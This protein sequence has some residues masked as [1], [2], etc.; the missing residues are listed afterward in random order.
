MNSVGKSSIILLLLVVCLPG[1]GQQKQLNQDTTVYGRTFLYGEINREGLTTGNN[2][3][4]FESYYNRYQLDEKTIANLDK[5]VLEGLSV[6][7]LMGTWCPDSKRNVPVFFKMMDELGFDEEKLEMHAL[8][9]RKK[10]P[11][12]VQKTY[13]VT[14][15]PT[16]I[17]YKNDQEIGRFVERPSGGKKMESMIAE[18]LKK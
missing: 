2:K 15:V 7:L 3:G 12:N 6:R 16:I 9:L 4:W 8:D 5:E 18:I 14:R 11:D 1:I 13:N 17:F 10:G